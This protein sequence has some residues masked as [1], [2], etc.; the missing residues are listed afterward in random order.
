MTPGPAKRI[1]TLL[2]KKSPT[3]IAPPMAS[4]LS[5]RWVSLRFSSPDGTA[6]SGKSGLPGGRP[7]GGSE[8]LLMPAQIEQNVC[9]ATDLFQSIVM[10]RGNSNYP[11]IL[12]Q[13]EAFHQPRCVHVAIA[14]RDTGFRHGLC[15]FCRRGFSQIEAD[16]WNAVLH[17]VILFYA[18]DG[19]TALP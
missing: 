15:H 18:V 7:L 2:P 11:A 4:M 3:P 19:G 1:V 17:A 10:N 12:T 14:Y 9:E 13:T 16:G 5:C 6:R 8:T